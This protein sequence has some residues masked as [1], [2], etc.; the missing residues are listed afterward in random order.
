MFYLKNDDMEGLF[1]K[2]AENYELDSGKAS[3]WEAV[4]LALTNVEPEKPVKK[5]KRRFLLWWLLL[6]PFGLAGTYIWKTFGDSQE[7]LPFARLQQESSEITRTS[8]AGKLGSTTGS[9]TTLTGSKENKK[10]ESAA[11]TT[12]KKNA[13]ISEAGSKLTTGGTVRA[14]GLPF[15]RSPKIVVVPDNNSLH[16]QQAQSDAGIANEQPNPPVQYEIQRVEIQRQGYTGAI[17]TNVLMR[18]PETQPTVAGTTLPATVQKPRFIRNP[19][20]FY[21]TAI[22]SPDFTMVKFQRVSGTGR[23]FG[24]LAGYRINRRFQVETGA[25]LEK[26][27]YYT[28]GKYFDKSKL[29]PYY[30][31]VK[32]LYVDGNCRMLTIPLNIRYNLAPGKQHNWFIAGGMS[33]YFMTS[34]YYDYTYQHGND[35]AKTKGYRYKKDEQNWLNVININLGY[36][37]SLWAKYHLR[38]E[39]YFRLPVTGVGTGNLSLS[40]AG[41]Y[42]GFGRRF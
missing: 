22:G 26:K 37:R 5:K 27:M 18:G 38:V 13:K 17:R 12:E 4:Q 10:Q 36:E 20:Y 34:E 41:I 42:F 39:P 31:Y 15:N 29:S 30:Q 21:L 32:M 2:A 14:P 6:I 19:R 24:L 28:N 33:S 1:R 8:D 25:Y 9:Q 3:N 35:P 11:N 7:K 23:S 40:S 16:W